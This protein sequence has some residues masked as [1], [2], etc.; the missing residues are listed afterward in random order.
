MIYKCSCPLWILAH[1]SSTGKRKKKK[2]T[3]KDLSTFISP[4]RH[5][6]LKFL[7]FGMD[8]GPEYLNRCLSRCWMHL[9]G[10]IIMKMIFLCMWR[11]APSSHSQ[12]FCCSSRKLAERYAKKWTPASADRRPKAEAQLTHE[13]P[14]HKHQSMKTEQ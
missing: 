7:A 13:Q 11:E 6:C 3:H 1:S 12:Q 8:T 5:C 10:V 4:C 14:S 9:D 2:N